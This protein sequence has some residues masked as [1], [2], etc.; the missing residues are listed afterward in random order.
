MTYHSMK[1]KG[2][3]S[4]GSTK[5]HVTQPFLRT[6]LSHLLGDTCV[7]WLHSSTL[8]K[9]LSHTLISSHFTIRFMATYSVGWPTLETNGWYLRTGQYNYSYGLSA[10][11][12]QLASQVYVS[13]ENSQLN[14]K[15]TML[16]KFTDCCIS[17]SCCVDVSLYTFISIFNATPLTISPQF[18]TTLKSQST[19]TCF[20]LTWP[21]S[22]SCS[23]FETATLH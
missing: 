5:F 14:N 20:W 13:K 16:I 15:I 8:S 6:W 17:A 22:D 3:E 9:T 12:Q 23:P 10:F 4:N 7:W 18:K 2:S 21:S 1:I 19:A 11:N